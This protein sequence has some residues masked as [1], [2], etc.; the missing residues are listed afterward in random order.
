MTHCFFK[1]NILSFKA[2]LSLRR[3]PPCRFRDSVVLESLFTATCEIHMLLNWALWGPGGE[4]ERVN[5]GE[6][7]LNDF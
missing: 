5:E 2:H 1:P 3:N 6:R 4:G 7:A